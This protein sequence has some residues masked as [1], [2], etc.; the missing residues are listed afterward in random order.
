MKDDTSAAFRE[1]DLEVIFLDALEITD[2]VRREQF[3]VQQCAG[4]PE[5]LHQVRE[6]LDA[7]E[8][9]SILDH[10]LPEAAVAQSLLGAVRCRPVSGRGRC[11]VCWVTGGWAASIWLSRSSRCGVLRR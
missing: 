3:L 11:G 4:R 7:G 1:S 10:P 2:P 8:R 5:L 9:P 6:L